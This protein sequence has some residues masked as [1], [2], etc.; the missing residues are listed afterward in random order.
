MD[1]FMAGP[2]VLGLFV[3]FSLIIRKIIID[4]YL[5]PPIPVI[6]CE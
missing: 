2:P 1:C 3:T 6:E 4:T 5:Y